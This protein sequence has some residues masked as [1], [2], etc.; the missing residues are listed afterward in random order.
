MEKSMKGAVKILVLFTFFGL[1]S[2]F[3]SAA[4]ADVLQSTKTVFYFQK[5]GRALNQPVEFTVKCYGTGLRDKK[6]ELY[7]VS[8]LSENCEAYGCGFDYNLT[9]Y[10]ASIK[11]CD[12][13][14]KVNG[15]EFKI[16]KFLEEPLDGLECRG[17][18]TGLW[19]LSRNGKYYKEVPE[20]KECMETI[21]K[22]Y[23]SD[24]GK[25]TCHQYLIEVPKNECG[26]YGWIT[27]DGVCYK[28]SD[29]TNTCIEEKG[30]KEILCNQ[31]LEDVSSQV[32]RNKQGFAFDLICETEVDI[33][34]G[35]GEN[36]QQEA[37]P[38]S[39]AKFSNEGFF[40]R[41]INFVRCGF[42]RLFGK[43]C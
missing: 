39:I 33:S 34:N 29:K 3:A 22:E 18:N 38:I 28:F 12:L 23:Y 15:K 36:Q 4:K 37:E 6:D 35:T 10:Q 5:E 41:V 24:N 17:A 11:Y 32:E 43:T 26:G 19:N 2:F 31:Y 21:R 16:D 27:I 1:F 20:Y 42:L 14:G 25:F 9:G 13:E 8:E 7:K 30:R 40:N